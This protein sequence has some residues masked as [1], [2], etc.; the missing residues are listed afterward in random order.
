MNRLSSP[1]CM[2]VLFTLLVAWPLWSQKS[3]SS[4]SGSS[5]S[6][7]SGSSTPSQPGGSV[8]GTRGQQP[9][10]NQPQFQTPVYVNGRIL[11]DTGQPVPEPVS[12]ALGCG[13]RSLQVIHTDLKGYFQFTLGAGTQSNVDFSASSDAPMSQTGNGMQT[14]GGE[15]RRFGGSGSMLTGCEVRVTVPGY[16]P[17][18]T[19]IT[20]HTELTGID[21]GTLHL[22]RMAGVTGSSISVTSLLVPNSA[23]KEFEK[24]DKEA[25]SSHLK[26]ATEHLEKAVAEYDMYAAAWNELGNIYATDREI[27]KSRQAFNKA[28]T[29]DPKYIPPYVS[30]ANLELQNQEF[31]PAVE[32]AGKA[33]ELDPSINAA[34]FIQAVGNFKLNRLDAA[35]KSAQNAEKGQHQNLQDLHALHAEI[36]LQ[37]Q[38]YSNAAAQMRAYLK[39]F[40]EG[41]F[42]DQMKK[43]LQQIEQSVTDAENKSDTAQPQTAP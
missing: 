31:G 10:L 23:R 38:D 2:A 25:R 17:I 28:I 22:T 18:T 39:E 14:P 19:T 43:D 24:G 29:A 15:Y 8:S 33:L 30:L 4:G 34:N 5:G 9:G 11:M 13:I 26:S 35:E 7:S 40:P 36:L 37:K 20:D 27:E 21:I 42:A 41:R 3:G 6:G 1:Y 32:T 16:L 12:V